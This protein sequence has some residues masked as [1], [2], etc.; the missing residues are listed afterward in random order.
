MAQ[1]L[2]KAQVVVELP[3]SA[4]PSL[5]VDVVAQALAP[6]APLWADAG[7][8]AVIYPQITF[9]EYPG[10]GPKIDRSTGIEEPPG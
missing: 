7:I 6:H 3:E 4:S 1:Y 2:V 9:E 10:G 8:R 5:A